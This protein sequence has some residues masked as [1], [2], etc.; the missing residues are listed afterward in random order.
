MMKNEIQVKVRNYIEMMELL[1]RRSYGMYDVIVDFHNQKDKNWIRSNNITLIFIKHD[2]SRIYEYRTKGGYYV[3]DKRDNSIILI[4][5]IYGRYEYFDRGNISEA[6]SHLECRSFFRDWW[7]RISNIDSDSLVDNGKNKEDYYDVP[8]VDSFHPE[9]EIRK[10]HTLNKDGAEYTNPF[11]L[12]KRKEG[13]IELYDKETKQLKYV[14]NIGRRYEYYFKGQYDRGSPIHNEKH[15][16]IIQLLYNDD[17][18]AWVPVFTTFPPDK[19]PYIVR[20]RDDGGVDLLSKEDGT[21][22]YICNIG[23]RFY[24]HPYTEGRR[25]Y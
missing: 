23:K 6:I 10:Y 11:I 13:G 25:Y 14:C 21:L 3:R 7:I 20:K 5:G 8:R 9:G 2:G 18:G 4:G 1:N 17:N 22:K 19:N 16:I 15:D 12:H 24:Y